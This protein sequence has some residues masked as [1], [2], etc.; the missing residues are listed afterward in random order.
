MKY[1]DKLKLYYAVSMPVIKV[2]SLFSWIWGI[3]FGKMGI[4]VYVA[5]FDSLYT[6][7]V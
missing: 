5:M 6:H 3:D 2:K 7:N 4:T 1:H